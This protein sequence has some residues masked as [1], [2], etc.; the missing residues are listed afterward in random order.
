[1]TYKKKNNTNIHSHPTEKRK[2]S[3]KLYKTRGEKQLY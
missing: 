3:N 1:M 2:K